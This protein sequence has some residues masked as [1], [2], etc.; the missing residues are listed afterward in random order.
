VPRQTRELVKQVVANKVGPGAIRTPALELRG[1][2]S[3]AVQT[4][5]EYPL[6]PSACK[7]PEHPE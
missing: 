3:A 7:H 6:E 2:M 5:Y 4:V 1:A